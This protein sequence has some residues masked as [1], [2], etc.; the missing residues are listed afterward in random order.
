[1]AKRAEGLSQ[2]LLEPSTAAFINY[3]AISPNSLHFVGTNFKLHPVVERG[4]LL[5]LKFVSYSK[6][7][8][9]SL[10]TLITVYAHEPKSHLEDIAHAGGKS[11]FV[12]NERLYTSFEQYMVRQILHHPNWTEL[13]KCHD[14]MESDKN[15]GTT[16]VAHSWSELH[17]CRYLLDETFYS[18][19][20]TF[21][22]QVELD[23]YNKVTNT[24]IFNQ[25]NNINPS[26]RILAP[27]P[28]AYFPNF[29]VI[30]KVH[31]TPTGTRPITGAF[32]SRTS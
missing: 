13:H 24:R 19:Y 9:K 8:H 7:Q 6:T 3:P 16:I 5:G 12:Q 26:Y 23:N 29:Y 30:S 11:A 2:I 17:C 1:M 20:K 4:L 15:M 10:S 31:K 21:E 14:I 32:N 25:L 18:T 22:S 28:N 27:D